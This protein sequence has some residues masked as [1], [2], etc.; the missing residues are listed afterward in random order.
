MSSLL[1]QVGCRFVVAAALAELL[2]FCVGTQH[3]HHHKKP[4]RFVDSGEDDDVNDDQDD[5]NSF[6][7]LRLGI[8]EVFSVC[9]YTMQEQFFHKLGY[10]SQMICIGDV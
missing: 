7:D 9:L 10:F 4:S 8:Q 6:R 3:H 5:F 2:L 1:L